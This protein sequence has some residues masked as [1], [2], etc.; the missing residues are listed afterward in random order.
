[1]L[2]IY[3]KWKVGSALKAFCDYN[4]IEAEIKDDSDNIEDFSGYSQIIPSPGVPPT[5]KIYST[6]KILW[7]LD[8]IYSFLPKWFKIITVTWTDGKSTTTWMLYSI[9]KQEFWENKV[10]LSGNFDEPF[11]DTLLQ[12]QQKKLKSG[13]IILE[14]SSFM[15]YNV[16]TF[17]TDYSIFTNF[18]DDHL[19]WHSDMQDYLNAKLNIFKNTTKKAIIHSQVFDKIKKSWLKLELT[20]YRVFWESKDKNLKDRVEMPYIII[21]WKKKYSLEETN[22]SWNFNALNLLSATLVTS[23]MKICSKKTKTYLKNIYWLSHRIEFVTEKSWVKFIDDSKSTSSQSL[24]AALTAFSWN[25]ILI[26]GWSDKWDSFEWL[27]NNLANKVKYWALIWKT[28]EIIAEKFE[29]AWIKYVLSESM[30][31]AVKKAWTNS[32]SWDII[33]L[34]PWC[35]SFGLFKDYLDRANKFREAINN[36][37]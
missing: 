10:F 2:L 25:I 4:K 30:E 35:A 13:Y 15:A 17:K 37:K 26:A 27:E 12:I 14:A 29:K 20:N 7:E 18:E 3:W 28:R 19:N 8:F 1:M 32:K 31:E 22:F 33:L 21:S 9:L 6:G 34:S 5:N 23:E 24:K 36:L 11:S 16:K